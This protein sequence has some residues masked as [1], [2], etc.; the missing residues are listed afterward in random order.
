MAYQ[1]R[2]GH[3]PFSHSNSHHRKNDPP[4]LSFDRDRYTSAPRNCAVIWI[5]SRFKNDE[6]EARTSNS[7]RFPLRFYLRIQQALRIRGIQP[8]QAAKRIQ[9]IRRARTMEPLL[10]CSHRIQSSQEV[11]EIQQAKQPRKCNYRILPARR[12]HRRV[13]V[14]VHSHVDVNSS[15]KSTNAVL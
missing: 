8:S 11:Q 4:H 9:A 13:L 5:L 7:V 15:S 12:I 14:Q 6:K 1:S 3:I 2:V 10:Q